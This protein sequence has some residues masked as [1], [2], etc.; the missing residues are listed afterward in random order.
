MEGTVALC[1]ATWC[2][3]VRDR[4]KNTE[5]QIRPAEDEVRRMHSPLQ[6]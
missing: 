6:D 2:L 3:E 1:G 4:E 5:Q